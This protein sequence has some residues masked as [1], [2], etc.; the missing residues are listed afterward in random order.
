MHTAL[1]PS[2]NQ[3]RDKVNILQGRQKVHILLK[4]F[5]SLGTGKREILWA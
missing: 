4:H 3:G 1:K 5:S 2:G